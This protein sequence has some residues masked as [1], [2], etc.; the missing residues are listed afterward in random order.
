MPTFNDDVVDPAV[1]SVH[2]LTNPVCGEH[3][4]EARCGECAA[5]IGSSDLGR[6]VT[7]DRPLEAVHTESRLERV[8]KLPADNHASRPVDDAGQIHMT[9]SEPDVGD[10]TCPDLI[11]PLD[12]EPVQKIGKL[13]VLLDGTGG[14]RSRIARLHVHLVHQAH[15]LMTC[16]LISAPAALLGHLGCTRGGQLEMHL[17]DYGHAGFSF[18]DLS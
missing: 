16:G 14:V 4:Y 17:I 15:R 11:R 6:A 8:R 10:V 2:R 7:F 13:R 3:V 1:A 12:P 9:S 5:L 18:L